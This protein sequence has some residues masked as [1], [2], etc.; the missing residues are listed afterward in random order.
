[1][2][3]FHLHVKNISR[4]EG[5]SIVAAAAYR[6]GE[7]LH[8]AAEERESNFGGRRDV[9]HA[10]IRA[11][12]HAPVWM[13]ER[14]ALWNGVEQAEL[15]KDARL[16]KEIEVALPREL[17]RGM[18]LALIRNFADTY[19]AQGF[20][21]DL[22]IH[23]D[24]EA[25]NP[26]A[27]LLLTTRMITS[28][29]FGPK[30]RE[31]DG[32]K[33]V[34]DARKSWAALA[35]VTFAKAGSGLT[36]DHRSHAEAGVEDVPTRHRGAD[37]SERKARRNRMGDER[38]LRAREELLATDG[39]EGDYPALVETAGWPPRDRTAPAGLTPAEARE[40]ET[41]WNEVDMRADLAEVRK[42]V[43]EGELPV[44]DPDG[45]PISQAERNHAEEGLLAAMHAEPWFT[46]DHARSA[47]GAR[48]PGEAAGRD[49][50]AQR[51]GAHDGARD[52][53]E[54]QGTPER[55]RLG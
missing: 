39:L 3:I 12:S 40:F 1:M 21:V 52:A 37:S 30:L 15:R 25:H 55:D 23:D 33:F 16:A 13:S 8:N 28:A 5:R 51:R 10:E 9:L 6:A 29:G 22:A 20:V 49:W 38:I 2:A 4:G 34:L 48:A 44:P 47:Q 45:N 24:G 42:P 41:F 27:H 31:A 43:D 32:K 19:V 14:S 46:Q 54:E 17:A 53:A 36:I 26:H 7:T 50:F 35:N 18:W 11:P